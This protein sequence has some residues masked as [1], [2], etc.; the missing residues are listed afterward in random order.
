MGVS[1]AIVLHLPM[2]FLIVNIEFLINIT[3]LQ[4]STLRLSRKFWTST[5]KELEKHVWVHAHASV[6]YVEYLATKTLSGGAHIGKYG[7][8]LA[9][10]GCFTHCLPHTFMI[11]SMNVMELGL[12][13]IIIKWP[14]SEELAGCRYWDFAV[15]YEA[16]R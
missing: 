1:P 15:L 6:I 8:E 16:G 13:F 3:H 2:F 11:Y 9:L 4:S 14:L 7:K 5:T 12:N 10:I